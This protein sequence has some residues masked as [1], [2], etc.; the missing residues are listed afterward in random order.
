MRWTLGHKQS[1][2][3]S[4]ILPCGSGAGWYLAR[5]HSVAL[6]VEQMITLIGQLSCNPSQLP[7][8]MLRVTLVVLHG[9]CIVSG[10]DLQHFRE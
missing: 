4:V 7:V 9:T 8:E 3:I 2:R 10:L 5:K 6:G 1:N